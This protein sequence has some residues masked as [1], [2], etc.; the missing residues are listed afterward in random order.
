M[1]L[2]I[3]DKSLLKEELITLL[4]QKQITTLAQASL[5]RDHFTFAEV[6]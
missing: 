5:A 1:I 3:G 4:N 6:W 2:G